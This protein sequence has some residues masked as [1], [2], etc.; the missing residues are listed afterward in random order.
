M[1]DVAVA[2]ALTRTKTKLTKAQTTGFLAAWFGWILDGV[3]SF[4]F[5]LVLG[6]MLNN[7]GAIRTSSE[8]LERSR[9]PIPLMAAPADKS[10]STASNL[11]SLTAFC[12]AIIF[13]RSF[14][15]A[16]GILLSSNFLI[17]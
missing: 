12:R 3:D 10:D 5:A 7:T 16:A 9:H 8:L 4:I 14:K 17:A 6:L 15:S 11:F 13:V 2:P 1:V